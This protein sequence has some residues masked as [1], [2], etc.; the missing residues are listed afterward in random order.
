MIASI[1]TKLYFNQ[2]KK[3]LVFSSKMA[4]LPRRCTCFLDLDQAGSV[5]LFER[6]GCLIGL[7]NGLF[8][9]F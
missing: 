5:S 8:L 1:G 6:T 2:T 9:D 4:A 7:Q 3:S